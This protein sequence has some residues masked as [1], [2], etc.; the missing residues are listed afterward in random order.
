[1]ECTGASSPKPRANTP[2]ERRRAVRIIEVGVQ[3]Y[4]PVMT[5][6][7]WH[8]RDWPRD[9]HYATLHRQVADELELGP[10]YVQREPNLRIHPP[11]SQGQRWH[12]DA[13]FGHL[14]EEWNIWVPLTEPTADCH[15]LWW[16]DRPPGGTRH[17]WRVKP[18]QSLAFRGATL[19]HGS[20]PNT[21]HST[22]VSFD[23]RL[24]E[25]EHYRDAGRT[26]VLHGVPMRLGDYWMDP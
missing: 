17:R 12:T 25:V 19:G 1:M 23:F 6:V 26:T 8:A 16:G 2:G 3:P 21:S 10:Y 14:L 4:D 5:E 9:R 11:G 22:R 18:G 15:L 13:E 7:E 20:D 24:I